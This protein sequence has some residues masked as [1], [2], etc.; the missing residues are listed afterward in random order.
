MLVVFEIAL[1][2]VALIG[3]GL[4]IRSMQYA[5]RLDPGFESEKL[6]MMAFDLGALHYEEGPRRSF[7]E[8]R[9]SA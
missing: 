1:A 4:F 2:L 5:Q 3:A 6:F 8:P 7:S 9:S